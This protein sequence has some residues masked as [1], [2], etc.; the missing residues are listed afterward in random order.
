[1][2]KLAFGLLIAGLILQVVAVVV[3]THAATVLTPA[4]DV[5][6]RIVIRGGVLRLGES[7]YIHDNST[8]ASVGIA[9]LEWAPNHCD[10]VVV[11]DAVDATDEVIAATAEEDESIS[12]LGIQAGISGGGSKATIF[13]Y[14]YNG[15]H[16]CANDSRFGT[17]SNLWISIISLS[18]EAPA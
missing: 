18:D 12:K 8:H 11:T 15:E 4:H 6:N 10:I 9:R 2:K 13:L 16:V 14:K 5:Q 7:I 3:V 1:V 17:V